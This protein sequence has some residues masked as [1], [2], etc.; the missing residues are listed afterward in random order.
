MPVYEEIMPKKTNTLIFLLFAFLMIYSPFH[1]GDW[2]LRRKESRYAA[3]AYEM[4]LTQPN[5]II[6]GEQVPFQY[7]FYPWIVALLY[8]MG[9][10]FQFA[11]RIVAVM[12]LA[13]LSVLVFEAGRRAVDKQ[14]GVVAAAMMFSTIII[15]EKTLDGYPHLMAL[16]FITSAWFSWF[17]FGVARSEWNKAWVVSFFFCGLGFYTLGWSAVIYFIVPLIFMRRPMTVWPKLK[18]PG[19]WVGVIILLSFVLLWAIPRWYT[20]SDIN[21]QALKS[22]PILL[23]KYLLHIISFPIDLLFRF[24]PWTILTWPAFCVAFF[25]LDKN[26]IFSRFLRTIVISLFFVLCFSPFTD[27]RDEIFLA[28]AMAVMCGI[29]YWLLVRRHGHQIHKILRFLAIISLISGVG[30]ILFYLTNFPW[31]WKLDFIPKNLSF[32]VTNKNYGLFLA[33]LSVA[34]A[35]YAIIASKKRLL[36]FSHALLLITSAT[37]IFWAV[38]IPFRST[39]KRDVVMGQ[40][41]ASAIK[42]DLHIN[43]KEEFPKDFVVY[44]GPGILGLK[45]PCIYMKTKVKKIHKLKKLPKDKKIVYMIGTDFPVSGNRTWTNITPIQNQESKELPFIYNDT[46]FYIFKGIKNKAG[47]EQ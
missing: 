24:M 43:T 20:D 9:L 8:K 3:I 34:L 26:P 23:K 39:N 31:D 28:P 21:F 47:K 29:N 42:K 18:K 45:A 19:F 1:L 13:L 37:L 35:A 14:T 33:G 5:T 2:Q 11:L 16:L 32:R 30:V 7:P 44:K 25:P 4:N 12:S 27:A 40:A 38:I 15:I 22:S 17:T 10:S 41:F 46:R 36:V 6:H